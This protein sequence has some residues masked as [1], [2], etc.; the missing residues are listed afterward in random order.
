MESSNNTLISV[1]VPAYNEEQNIAQIYPLIKSNLASISNNY[2]IIFVDD[3]STDNSFNTI[4]ELGVND[5]KVIGISLSRNFG[6]QIALMAGLEHSKGDVVITIDAD[7][8]HPPEV[9]PEL[10]DQ[11]KKGFDIVNTIRIDPKGTNPFKKFS[12]YMYYKLVNL[13]SDTKIQP[14]S[15]DYRLMNRKAVDALLQLKERDRFT[16]GL[17]SWM[18]FE[19]TYISYNASPRFQGKSKYT[20]AKMLR[21]AM[22]GITS[23]SA[24]PLRISFY[25]GMFIAFIGVLYAVFAIVSYFEGKTVQ[26]WTSILVSVL[27]IGGIQLI[28]IGIIGEYLARVF[29]EAKGRPLYFVKE[30]TRQNQE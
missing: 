20:I 30:Y 1:V 17:V 22:S 24:K 9:F 12:S 23:F 28:S 3:G 11:Y 18:G 4:K 27:I 8:Q 13:L 16:R 15:A 6:H 25:I 21:F 10:Y 7:L 29:K 14:A 26:G 19:Q 5:N 2:E